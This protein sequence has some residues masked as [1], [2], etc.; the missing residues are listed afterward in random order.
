M[1]NMILDPTNLELVLD[2]EADVVVRRDFTHPLA[3]AWRAQGI[4]AVFA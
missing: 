3:L 2:G 1:M 4:S